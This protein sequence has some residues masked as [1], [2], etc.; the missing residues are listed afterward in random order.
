MSFQRVNYCSKWS[1]GRRSETGKHLDLYTALHQ[2]HTDRCGGSPQ[3]YPLIRRQQPCPIP[4]PHT[5]THTHTHIHTHTLRCNCWP[6]RLAVGPQGEP[7]RLTGT[8]SKHTHTHAHTHTHRGS[9]PRSNNRRWSECVTPQKQLWPF[10][11]AISL[12][13][14]QT[15]GESR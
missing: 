6:S 4:C 2:S 5:H 15:E 10:L 12:W 7:F 13:I 14:R 3:E 11:R 1:H 9:G 8:E